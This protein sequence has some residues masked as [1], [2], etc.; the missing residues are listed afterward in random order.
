M[1][2]L[3]VG[4]FVSGIILT[5]VSFAGPAGACEDGAD[6]GTDKSELRM[7]ELDRRQPEAC[8]L[9]DG[10]KCYSAKAVD[11]ALDTIL[12]DGAFEDGDCRLKDYA[13]AGNPPAPQRPKSRP[14]TPAN[15]G[16]ESEAEADDESYDFEED[17]C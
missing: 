13:G 3:C 4:T 8:A 14:D 7:A 17:G 1:R 11:R 10:R 15:A 2:A 5:A 9:S 16:N 12:C 6:C